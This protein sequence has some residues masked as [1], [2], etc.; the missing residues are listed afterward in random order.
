MYQIAGNHGA[1]DGVARAAP[2]RGS[3]MPSAQRLPP[4]GFAPPFLPPPDP[5]RA[6]AP[7]ALGGACDDSEWGGLWAE[8]EEASD[9]LP[10]AVEVSDLCSATPEGG[11]KG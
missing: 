9:G 5:G 10:V 7:A 6:V 11:P 8:E 1:A 3:Q 4:L 2:E